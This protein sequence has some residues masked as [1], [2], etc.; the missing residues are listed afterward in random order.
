[1]TLSIDSLLCNLKFGLS[2]HC[3]TIHCPPIFGISVVVSSVSPPIFLSPE[4]LCDTLGKLCIARCLC[5]LTL[6]VATLQLCKELCTLPVEVSFTC[7]PTHVLNM[8]SKKYYSLDTSLTTSSQCMRVYSALV[9]V[10]T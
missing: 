9:V 5:C 7:G 6:R 2:V 8:L 4:A 1:M 10:R 3:P